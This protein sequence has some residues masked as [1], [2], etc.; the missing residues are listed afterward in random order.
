[1]PYKIKACA[2]KPYQP[3]NGTEGMSFFAEFCDRCRYQL[4]ESGCP[5]Q[6]QTMV[7][8]VGDREYPSQYWV[9]DNEGQ[10]SCTLFVKG[11]PL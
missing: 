7:F 8:G 10:P 11:E 3:S 4:P 6:N 1:M 5:I 2:G 9:H